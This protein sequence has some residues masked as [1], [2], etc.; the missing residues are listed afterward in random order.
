MTFSI[1]DDG[2]G[3]Y[4][5][6]TATISIPHGRPPDADGYFGI[7]ITAYGATEAE[8]RDNVLATAMAASLAVANA[9]LEV[10]QTTING[11]ERGG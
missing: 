8:A 4:Q 2:K 7:E 6:F 3:K 10:S 9:A 11:E 5:S 1:E